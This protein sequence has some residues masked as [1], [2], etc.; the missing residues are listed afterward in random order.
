MKIEKNWTFKSQEVADHFDNHVREQLPWY[1]LASESVVHFVRHYLPHNGLVYDIGASTGNFYRRLYDLINDREATYVA[2]DNS[3]EMI[4]KW[5][6]I[7]LESNYRI[8]HADADDYDYKSFD[9]GILFL[10][11]MFIPYASRKRLIKQLYEQ[12]K[13]GG[14]IIIVDKE[15]QPYG[16]YGT[17]LHRLTL[18]GKINQGVKPQEI[19]DKELSLQGVQRPIRYYEL[20][21][22]YKPRQFFRFG[23]FQGI[24]IEKV[25]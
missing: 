8:H 6:D 13:P 2:I 22:E 9:C 4:D 15:E 20:F 7:Y 24:L 3:E 12:C 11:L 19:I 16:Y 25:F 5:K 17:A 14:V 1:D 21:D 10:V 18:Q 23:E